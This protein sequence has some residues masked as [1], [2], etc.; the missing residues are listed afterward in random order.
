M[1]WH[2]FQAI[3]VQSEMYGSTTTKGQIF[4]K[5]AQW[6]KDNPGAKKSHETIKTIIHNS[7]L[8][9]KITKKDVS[10][11]DK[12]FEE[13]NEILEEIKKYQ[14]ISRGNYL[15]L[16]IIKL[17]FGKCGYIEQLLKYDLYTNKK[18]L[19]QN[20]VNRWLK[21]ILDELIVKEHEEFEKNVGSSLQNFYKRNDTWSNIQNRFRRLSRSVDK[22]YKEIFP[23]DL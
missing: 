17:V 15:I 1:A 20:V 13:K 21:T 8:F 12:F 16:A 22:E 23:L 4:S 19:S 10:D 7:V 3:K 18:F 14:F 5:I 6:N 11:F 9:G 2:I